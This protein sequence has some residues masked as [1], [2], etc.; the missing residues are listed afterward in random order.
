MTDFSLN[1]TRPRPRTLAYQ[2]G[3][4]VATRVPGA[5]MARRHHRRRSK[6]TRVVNLVKK[7]IAFFFSHV[8][9]CAL[10]SGRFVPFRSS[11][12]LQNSHCLIGSPIQLGNKYWWEEGEHD[13]LPTG[14]PGSDRSSLHSLFKEYNRSLGAALNHLLPQSTSPTVHKS[15]LMHCCSD[16]CVS[17]LTLELRVN[18]PLRVT[19]ALERRKPEGT[20][21]VG[22]DKR[23]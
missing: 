20:I 4:R 17:T 15:N 5:L 18:L 10:V 19:N 2:G 22:S 12:P 21:Y 8:G 9:L 23:S 11:T 16:S 6:V 3:R 13:L 14:R 1:A 7:I